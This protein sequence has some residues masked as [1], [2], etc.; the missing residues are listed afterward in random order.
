MALNTQS[1]LNTVQAILQCFQS[2]TAKRSFSP[3]LRLPISISIVIT[4]LE[5][6]STAPRKE[7]ADF[8]SA[9]AAQVYIDA[10]MKH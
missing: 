3:R 9:G 8:S 10:S 7:G 2:L 5:S 4:A 1:L 6:I